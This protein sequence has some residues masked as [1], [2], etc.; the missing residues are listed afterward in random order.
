MSD[1]HLD[2][3]LAGLQSESPPAVVYFV[4]QAGP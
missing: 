4:A 1:L 2:K 3:P